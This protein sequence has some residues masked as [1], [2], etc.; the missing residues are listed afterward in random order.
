MGNSQDTHRAYVR[1]KNAQEKSQRHPAFSDY[2]QDAKE[3]EIEY[4][5]AQLEEERD[6]QRY[7]SNW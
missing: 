2:K 5:K 3:K 1:M 7:R 6:N 4:L